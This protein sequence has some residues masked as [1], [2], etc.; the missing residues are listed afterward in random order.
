M[1]PK[2]NITA[3][4]VNDYRTELLLDG[5]QNEKMGLSTNDYYSELKN[6]WTKIYNLFPVVAKNTPSSTGRYYKDIKTSP[7]NMNYY[8]DLLSSAGL[9]AQYGISTIGK[10]T[11]V[12]S[13]NNINCIFEPVCPEI[14]FLN[15]N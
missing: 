13:N 1:Q 14:Y 2:K 6:E 8:L 15:K 11:Q 9:I 4:V 10:R 12:I 7:T 5:I 3:F